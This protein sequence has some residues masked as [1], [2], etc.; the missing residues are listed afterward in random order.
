MANDADAK[1]KHFFD[2]CRE[3]TMMGKKI[4]LL[5]VSFIILVAFLPVSVT[6]QDEAAKEDFDFFVSL[7]GW[8]PN[9]YAD[10]ATGSESEIDLGTI[11]D[12]LQFMVMTVVG[13]KK[14]KWT[15]QT[16][17]IYLDLEDDITS[18]KNLPSLPGRPGRP[19]NV[20]ADVDL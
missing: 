10:S 4:V 16:D 3:E 18:T 1:H 14:D 5:F 20:Y 9:I 11:L 8:M 6:A 19:V 13:V 17:V 12:N 15:F 7:Y 2:V